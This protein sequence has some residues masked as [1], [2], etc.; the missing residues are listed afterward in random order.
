MPSP[1][2]P[3]RLDADPVA[4]QVERQLATLGVLSGGRFDLRVAGASAP[5]LRLEQ[6]GLTSAQVL[7]Q[8]P[9]LE[10]LN[11]QGGEVLIRPAAG[12]S[13]TILAGVTHRELEAAR[14]AGLGPAIVLRQE[15]LRRE[16]WFFHPAPLGP[17]DPATRTDL[18]RRFHR[19]TPAHDGFGHLAG[20]LA[21]AD[22]RA[23]RGHGLARTARVTLVE[24]GGAA[25]TLSPLPDHPATTRPPGPD[26]RRLDRQ[27]G[28][29]QRQENTV[30]ATV[31]SYSPTPWGVP[32]SPPAT[33]EEAA[34]ILERYEWARDRHGSL[35]AELPGVD[36]PR[37]TAHQQQ[38]V[39]SLREV[40]ETGWRLADWARLPR[41]PSDPDLPATGRVTLESRL[42]DR[43]ENLR[44]HQEVGGHDRAETQVRAAAPPEPV[45]LEPSANP[46][47]PYPERVS[48]LLARE[49][50]AAA[51][52]LAAAERRAM[53]DPAL[54]LRESFAARLERVSGLED[55][56][57]A[58]SVRRRLSDLAVADR[59]LAR[60]AAAL[61]HDGSPHLVDGYA[62]LVEGRQRLL[63]CAGG[64]AGVPAAL[65]AATATP[66]AA[67]QEARAALAR[68]ASCLH[69]THEVAALE[70]ARGTFEQLVAGTLRTPAAE[71]R[72]ELRAARAALRRSLAELSGHSEADRTRFPFYFERWDEAL[73]RHQMAET[74]LA[75]HLLFA[76]RPDAG[77]EDRL[78]FLLDR[79][80][81]GD[82][83]P[84]TLSRLHRETALALR[85]ATGQAPLPPF[86]R[87]QETTIA[88]AAHHHRAQRAALLRSARQV[89][90]GGHEP[91]ALERL[92]VC[93]G[94]AQHAAVRVEE[95]THR[96]AATWRHVGGRE[97]PV[98]V[99]GF[100]ND[101]R[102]RHDPHRAVAA[103]AVQATRRLAPGRAAEILTRSRGALT[104]TP[105]FLS[106]GFALVVCAG[107]ARLTRT[108]MRAAVADLGQEI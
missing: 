76:A 41:S 93:L 46:A 44:L 94:R 80:A 15:G 22:P 36:P 75:R 55:S 20:F 85:A 1:P 47:L 28:Y 31:T 7:D 4:A 2:T 61:L 51:L 13:V 104:S 92:E 43:I 106:P 17:D 42:R 65:P 10:Y 96:Y 77:R 53:R 68:Q 99:A 70:A 82:L 90:D 49:L 3:A 34:A 78:A 71:L 24:A 57:A 37:Q 33:V 19:A 30:L 35:L 74:A 101:P 45:L 100:L 23:P 11:A 8:V 26:G 50:D 67:F 89:Q 102:F 63:A 56:L 18:G 16:A 83:T 95:L 29:H 14:S 108:F 103:W 84:Q 97:V 48:S 59:D 12:P 81:A 54:A 62:G 40:Q 107:A 52:D 60:H 6:A 88:G 27:D 69:R 9:Y 87:F 73:A 58:L 86:D 38:L 21:P 91:R 5:A 66:G 105:S 25:I 39:D 64:E 72:A 79:L 98:P 32:P